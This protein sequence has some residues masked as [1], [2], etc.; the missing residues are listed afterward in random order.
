MG[1][2]G[3]DLY[4]GASVSQRSVWMELWVIRNTGKVS[5]TLHSQYKGVV[6]REKVYFKRSSFPVLR[7]FLTQTNNDSSRPSLRHSI[8]S[9]YDVKQKHY[10]LF[11]TAPS[12]LW[13]LD[14]FW[15][16]LLIATFSARLCST[17][18]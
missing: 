18:W 10:L 4:I 15:L 11:A 9:C 8:R 13:P 16:S 6:L 12:A 2:Q 5:V 3:L 1:I 14:I 7:R 17:G